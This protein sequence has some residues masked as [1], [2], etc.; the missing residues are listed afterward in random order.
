MVVCG[1]AKSKVAV[2]PRSWSI[3]KIIVNIYK[4]RGCIPCDGTGRHFVLRMRL[5]W[6]QIPP[7][8]HN[9]SSS[10]LGQRTF[11]A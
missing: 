5:L 10:R 1:P 3:K 6:V 11:N 7:G 4:N 9:L 8:L 2:Q